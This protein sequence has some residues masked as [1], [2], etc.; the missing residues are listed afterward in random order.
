MER[1]SNRTKSLLTVLI[2]LGL[3]ILAVVIMA[4][5]AQ[6][7]AKFI[8]TPIGYAPPKLATVLRWRV[9]PVDMRVVKA[10]RAP[11]PVLAA[12]SRPVVATKANGSSNRFV[13]P[14]G[15][16]ASHAQQWNPSRKYWGKYQFDRS[17]WAAHGGKPSEYGSAPESTQ[18]TIAA[19]VQYDAWPNC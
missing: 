13:N 3:V 7:A 15:C 19:K 1:V 8:T 2:C 16:E 18:D 17:T 10:L 9:V 4:T 14:W 11:R 12:V 6:G 5:A